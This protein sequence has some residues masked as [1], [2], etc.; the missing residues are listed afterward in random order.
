M[1]RIGK[2]AAAAFLLA[3]IWCIGWTMP[4]HASGTPSV[5]L[6]SAGTDLANKTLW[7]DCN[8]EQMDTVTNGKVRIT[9]DGNK[10][11]LLENQK[12]GILADGMAET[13][14]CLTGNKKEGEIVIAFASSGEL[15]ARGCLVNM[16]FSITDQ[17]AD[18]E[19]VKLKVAVE[20]LAGEK[21][22]INADKKDLTV[23][24]K[25]NNPGNTGGSQSGTNGGGQSGTGIGSG[26]NGGQGGNAGPSS[27]QG[28]RSSIG[29]GR[30]SAGSSQSGT[31]GEG[32]ASRSSI[33]NSQIGKDG[34]DGRQ[35]LDASDEDGI[36]EADPQLR[37]V[38]DGQVPLA[39]AE[40]GVSYWWI[41][42]LIVL[43]AGIVFLMWK[44]RQKDTENTKNTGASE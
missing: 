24:I 20:K 3:F 6:E 7:V 22:D 33:K 9:Y 13:N 40:S 42:P 27:I 26:A 41:I 30:N 4:A 23:K 39:A 35:A 12:G 19:E 36:S 25:K 2:R 44:K 43:A 11:K 10:L 1:N 37:T 18:G 34:E 5:V 21:G 8:L 14:D 16:K 28:N 15:P 31:N 38:S 17:T 29:T 32:A